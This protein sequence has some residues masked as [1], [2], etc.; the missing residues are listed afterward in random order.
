[1]VLENINFEISSGEFCILKGVS[2]SGK[3]TLL[4]FIA[5]FERP[6]EE[7]VYI[8]N[9]PISKFLDL[10]Q[11]KLRNEKIGFVFQSFNLFEDMSVRDNVTIPL[12]PRRLQ[13]DAVEVKIKNALELVNITHKKDEIV[14]NI[15]GKEKQILHIKRMK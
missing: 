13:S 15:S 12:I 4:S 8:V 11:S 3:T 6:S 5:S 2:G 7:V 9:E 1:V 14:H 10:H